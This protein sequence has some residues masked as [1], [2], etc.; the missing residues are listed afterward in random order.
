MGGGYRN[1][2]DVVFNCLFEI[3]KWDLH[4]GTGNLHARGPKMFREA[5]LFMV[6]GQVQG[7]ERNRTT[8]EGGGRKIL[9]VSRRGGK[10]F[11]SSP[12]GMGEKFWSW[13]IFFSMFLK[14]NFFMFW[15]YFGHFS[16]FGP[17][18][19]EKFKMRREG[20][21]KFLRPQGGAKNFRRLII[22]DSLG[23]K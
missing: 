3:Y 15:G 23:A 1:L 11:W 20:G 4:H 9:D 5:S 13:S 19:C 10:K 2:I 21:R 12:E 17:R 16:F 18:G 22:S 6:G 8:R 14:H 7:G